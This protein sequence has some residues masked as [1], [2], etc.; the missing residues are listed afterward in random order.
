MLG[1]S[2]TTFKNLSDKS[3]EK[4]KQAGLELKAIIDKSLVDG[5]YE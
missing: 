2:E 4:K 5:Q 3:S 1:I